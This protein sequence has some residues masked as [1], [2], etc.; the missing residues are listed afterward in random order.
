MDTPPLLTKKQSIT[1]RFL[2]WF[3]LFTA[4]GV[5]IHEVAHELVCIWQR[6]PIGDVVYFQLDSPA[7]YVQHGKPT[8]WTQAF[9][10]S[11]APLFINLFVA[12][13]LFFTAFTIVN[14]G[15][16]MLGV[17]VVLIW[18]GFSA[19]VHCLPSPQDMENLWNYTTAHIIRYPL[20]V[21]VGPLYAL[22]ILM[23]TFGM[24]FISVPLAIVGIA[25][26][27]LF[28]HIDPLAILEC[29]LQSQWGC[30]SSRSVSDIIVSAQ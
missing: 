29:L 15:L 13:W 16:V 5:V 9:L 1:Q 14:G 21:V 22:T 4:P 25:A 26:T 7:G 11:T 20:L 19:I 12:M 3:L 2:N 27:I 10:I 24:Y 17:G 8:V 30:W 23:Y 18:L 6:I 28:L